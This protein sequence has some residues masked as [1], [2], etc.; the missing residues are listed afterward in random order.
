MPKSFTQLVNE[1][2]QVILS[3]NQ[4]D[5]ISKFK[6]PVDTY[7]GMCTAFCGRWLSDPGT[8]QKD[9]KKQKYQI[10]TLNMFNRY[11]S[12]NQAASVT[13]QQFFASEFKNLSYKGGSAVSDIEKF[14][15]LEYVTSGG[16]GDRML[17]GV[18]GSGKGHALA[19]I[20]SGNDHW[21]LDPNEGFAYFSTKEK[22]ITF[23][24]FYFDDNLRKIDKYKRC[25]VDS[26]K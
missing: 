5:M 26:W 9:C 3:Y 15:F 7:N 25:F 4:A 14:D 24:A 12:Q 6:L 17:F 19:A 1:N 22:F 21:F 11:K 23:V 10:D 16:C 18:L 8:C 13:P 2:G 20:R